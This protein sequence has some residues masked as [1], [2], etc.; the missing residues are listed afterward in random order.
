[1]R[2]YPLL[3][4]LL[5]AAVLPAALHAEP[6]TPAAA[7]ATAAEAAVRPMDAAEQKA[8]IEA[9][10]NELEA[11]FVFPDVA[12]RYAQAIRANLAAGAYAP[13]T[14]PDAFG[15]RVTADLQA[16]SPDRH[17][18]LAPETAFRATM[19][20]MGLAPGGAKGKAA[21]TLEEAK[22]IGD[23]AYLRFNLFSNDPEVAA[24]AR[25]FLVAHADAKA[26]IIDC[27]PNRGGSMMVMDAILPLLFAQK[28]T[29]VRMD[30]REAASEPEDRTGSP[31]L[32]PRPAPASI[33]RV[34]HVVTPDAAERRLQRV[35]VYYLTSKRTGSAAEHLALAF[36]H[37]RRATVIGE[38]TSGAG[39][40]GGLSPVGERFAAFIP[41][42]RTY[43][44][45]TGED[46]E[47]KGVAPDVAVPA[48]QAL[49]EA[50]RR[51]AAAGARI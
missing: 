15:Q 39:H 2:S 27:R 38:T 3:A 32:A 22:M 18:R 10:A 48:D 42:G 24:R 4:A 44:P 35:P 41:V 28:S 9:F 1:V 16:I 45:D 8:V 6:A 25:A 34:D 36:K 17:L 13:I 20:S 40:Y 46:W 14:D 29:L 50:L 19:R 37:T 12:V 11:Q 23:V 51:A 33:L 43:D 31:T 49:D 26:V 47:A 7:P 5:A 30:T 21:D